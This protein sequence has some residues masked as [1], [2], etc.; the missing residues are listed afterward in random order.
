MSV[1]FGSRSDTSGAAARAMLITAAA[2]DMG[3]VE[4][5]DCFAEKGNCP[6]NPSSGRK[7]AYAMLAMKAAA[8]PV[9]EKIKQKDP[10]K[11][12]IIGKGTRRLDTPAKVE[13]YRASSAST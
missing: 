13:R 6:S 5:S 2:Q 4:A 12:S 7:M 1:L 8:L 9:P 11:F 3:V 10:T